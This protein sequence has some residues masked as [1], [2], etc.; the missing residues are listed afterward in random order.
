METKGKGV[1][2]CV[3]SGM[4]LFAGV[5]MLSSCGGGKSSQSGPTLEGAKQAFETYIQ[6][7]QHGFHGFHV[8]FQ[9]LGS[10]LSDLQLAVEHQQ[11]VIHIGYIGNHLCLYGL[12]IEL[13]LFQ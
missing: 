6:E 3:L 12:F 2:L 1:L 8:L 7:M 5:V 13:R 9:D 4:L 11:G 10:L